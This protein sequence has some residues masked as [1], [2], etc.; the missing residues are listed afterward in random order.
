MYLARAFIGTCVQNI[1][2]VDK[3]AAGARAL[4]YKELE[5]DMKAMVAPQDPNADYSGW[6]VAEK[7]KKPYLVGISQAKLNGEDYSICVI[8]NPYVAIDDVLEEI[9]NLTTLDSQI[10]NSEEAGQRYRVWATEGI[11]ARSFVSAVD[12]PQMGIV[13]GTIS[14]SAPTEK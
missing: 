14:L 4:G 9:Q 3:V 10:A 7:D 5:G 13:G 8:A 1:G 12:A 2:R 11:A 6:L